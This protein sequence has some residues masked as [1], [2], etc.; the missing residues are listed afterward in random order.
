MQTRSIIRLAVVT[1]SLSVIGVKTAGAEEPVKPQAALR[2]PAQAIEN[3]LAFLIKDTAKWRADRGCATCHHGTMSVWAL[4]EAKSQGYAVPAEALAEIT[5][6]TKGRM[7]AKIPTVRDPRPGWKLVSIPAIYLGTMSQNLPVLSRDELNLVAVHLARHQEEDGSFLLPIPQANGAPPIWESSETLALWALL[8]WDPLTLTDPKEAAAVRASREKTLSWLSK[9]EPTQTTQSLALWLLLEVR[10]GQA[11]EQIQPR[12][13]NLLK[14]QN[15]DGGWSQTKERPS[16]A[17]ATGQALYALSFAGVNRERPEIQRA[18][19][20]LAATQEPDGSWPMTSRNHPGVETTKDPI[21]WPVPIKYFGSAWAVLGLVR[22]VPT[23]PDT[24]AKQRVAF[25]QIRGFHGK[26]EVDETDPGK[27]VIGV[28]LRYYE[29]SDKEVGDFAK[30]LQAFP[31]LE[32]LQ[33]KSTKITDEGLAH[34][35]T[36]PHLRTLSL[37]N[38]TITDAGL[39]HLK[40]L[41]ELEVL[42][43]A[44][45]KVTDA[46]IQE[47]QKTLPKVKVER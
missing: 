13:D 5:E 29:V 11:A 40:A 9:A 30:W 34:L 37:E 45:T 25:D 20:Y 7:V 42:G 46:G 28:D 3:A 38:A 47:L 41:A 1:L 33:F 17:F 12:I 4:S 19:A 24:P 18:I 2:K 23:P 15:S 21:R 14:Q 8:A 32:K 31:R 22:S 10:S 27:P 16:D 43:L 44:G 39:A 36:L 26:H 6:W 35:K